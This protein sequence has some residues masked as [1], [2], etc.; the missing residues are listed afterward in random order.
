MDKD[1]IEFYSMAETD[2]LI[3][4]HLSYGPVSIDKFAGLLVE[5]LN[6]PFIVLFL[7]SK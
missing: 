2:F 6:S 7:F 4:R 5:Q 1:L 3:R